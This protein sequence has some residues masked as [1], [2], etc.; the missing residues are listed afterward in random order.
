MAH[1]GLLVV[2]HAEAKVGA[3]G[4]KVVERGSEMG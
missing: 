2:E 4:A 3:A 1:R